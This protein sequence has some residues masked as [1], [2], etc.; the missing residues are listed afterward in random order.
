[1]P[2]RIGGQRD[3]EADPARGG[4]WMK[5]NIWIW[6]PPRRFAP[7]LLFQEGSRNLKLEPYLKMQRL[8]G[9]IRMRPHRY[10]QSPLRDQTLTHAGFHRFRECAFGKVFRRTRKGN[11]SRS[12]FPLC[13]KLPACTLCRL[14]ARTGWRCFSAG[15]TTP[16]IWCTSALRSAEGIE[17]LN[18]FS[19]DFKTPRFGMLFRN[20]FPA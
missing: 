19:K 16:A 15:S 18:A 11:R 2:P 10:L 7:P 13:A 6:L 5:G 17:V 20:M 8:R 9:S 14:H 1:M 3:R 4:S 12:R